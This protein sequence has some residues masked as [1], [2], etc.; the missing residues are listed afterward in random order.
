MWYVVLSTYFK[1]QTNT[2]YGSYQKKKIKKKAYSSTSNNSFQ[3]A[4]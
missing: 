1:G 4:K 3:T 2:K